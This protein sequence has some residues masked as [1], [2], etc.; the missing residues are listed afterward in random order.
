MTD[1]RTLDAP[2]S[3]GSGVPQAFLSED[4]LSADPELRERLGV[5]MLRVT[6]DGA[7]IDYRPALL[8]RARVTWR[9]DRAVSWRTADVDALLFPLPDAP[10]WARWAVDRLASLPEQAVLTSQQR[11]ARFANLPAWLDSVTMVRAAERAFERALTDRPRLEVPRCVPLD[12]WGDPGEPLPAFY[13]RLA[14]ELRVSCAQLSEEKRWAREHQREMLDKRVTDVREALEM[15]RREIALLK[16]QG[17]EAEILAR[18]ERAI[19]GRMDE[20]REKVRQRD[21][22]LGALDLELANVELDALGKLEK[23]ELVDARLDVDKVTPRWLG[24]LWIPT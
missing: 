5:R 18:V 10:D 7:A 3:S 21:D 22:V 24:V 11:P 23:A 20:Y 12:R 14:A 2:P 17:A 19:R 6:G 15:D 9:P 1:I 13:N 16:E 8:A 4:A